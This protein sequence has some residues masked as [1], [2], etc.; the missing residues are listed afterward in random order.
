M[1]QSRFWRVNSRQEVSF[2]EWIEPESENFLFQQPSSAKHWSRTFTAQVK[3]YPTFFGRVLLPLSIPAC[4]VLQLHHRLRSGLRLDFP[5]A[6]KFRDS[7][8]CNASPPLESFP[9]G[10]N[11]FIVLSQNASIPPRPPR[12]ATE[13]DVWNNTQPLAAFRVSCVI[14]S[15]R[16]TRFHFLKGVIS[17]PLPLLNAAG[18]S[19][20]S[21]SYRRSYLGEMEMSV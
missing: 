15:M 11:V 9:I 21:R 13:V 4:V 18:S 16:R 7:R 5:V 2:L 17:F 20:L 19:G 14:I 6:F 10:E 1:K 8:L 3:N 12:S